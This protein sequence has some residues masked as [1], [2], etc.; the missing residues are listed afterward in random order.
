MDVR[1]GR[2][3]RGPEQTLLLPLWGRYTENIKD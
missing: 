3:L 1:E 2:I